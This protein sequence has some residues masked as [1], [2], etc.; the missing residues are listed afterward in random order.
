M[1]GER[2]HRP[3]LRRSNPYRTF[4]RVWGAAA[5]SPSAHDDEQEDRLADEHDTEDDGE[6]GFV[7]QGVRAAYTVIDAYLRQGRRVARRLG[8]IS[9]PALMSGRRSRERQ[10]RFL[11][12]TSELTANTF[13]MLGLI[14]E[15]FLP[16]D[17]IDRDERHDADDE[18]ERGGSRVSKVAVAYD[19]VSARPALVQVELEPDKATGHITAHGLRS[20]KP[21]CTPIPVTFETLGENNLVVRIRVPDD[22]APGLYTDV[23]LDSE[24]GKIV[25]NM[26]LELR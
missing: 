20:L 22:Q 23:L 3:K 14:T 21:D 19:I 24:T 17:D 12:L 13:E 6:G 9:W 5:A 15:M 11:Q 8:R 4:A 2:I 7:D 16:G 25:G 10:A 18:A 26:S 1:D